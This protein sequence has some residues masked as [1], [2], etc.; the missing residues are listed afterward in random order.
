M[1]S[2]HLSI[3]HKAAMVYIF[4]GIV[5]IYKTKS[6]QIKHAFTANLSIGIDFLN[7]LPSSQQL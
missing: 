6:K 1:C 2:K 3:P 5:Q 7:T 4:I